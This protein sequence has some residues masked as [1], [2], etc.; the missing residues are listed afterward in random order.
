MVNTDI[1]APLAG[2]LIPLADVDDPIFADK[3]M[4]DGFALEPTGNR[5]VAP[6][7][8]DVIAMQGHAFGLRRSDGLEIL[9]HIGIDTNGLNGKPFSWRIKTGD[10]VKAGDDVGN[11]D[12]AAIS[13]ANL[14][15]TTMVVITNSDDLLEALTMQTYKKATIGEVVASATVKNISSAVPQQKAVDHSGRKYSQL[16]SEIIAGVGGQ[17]NVDSVIHCITR[18]RF[19]LKDHNVA[20]DQAV[21][22]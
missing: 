5:I 12:L 8:G 16:A 17:Q 18:L 22:Q 9:I 15:T 6:V 7:S 21:E 11:V 19:Y 13:S 3:V 2:Q 14:S 20:N 10:V 1:L 4:G